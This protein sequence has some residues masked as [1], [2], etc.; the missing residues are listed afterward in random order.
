VPPQ[1]IVFQPS[2][3]DPRI[4]GALDAQ[5]RLGVAMRSL[6]MKAVEAL[7]SPGLIVNAPINRIADRDD[8]LARLRASEIAYEDA[9][10]TIEFAGVRGD[11]VVIMGE[12]IVAPTANAPLAGR[13]AHRR[14]TDVWENIDGL[15]KL[16]IRQATYVQV[17]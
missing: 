1:N 15:W 9:Q 3:D 13:V 7:M 12:E 16:A 17:Q 6:D 14:F 4:V 10:R 11:S 8:V 2:K 5:V